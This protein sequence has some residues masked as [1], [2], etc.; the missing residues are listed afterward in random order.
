[1]PPGQRIPRRRGAWGVEAFPRRAEVDLTSQTALKLP[2]SERGADGLVVRDCRRRSR[3]EV[4]K[5]AGRL[6]E[7]NIGEAMAAGEW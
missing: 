5:S 6:T 1:M 7:G 2:L 3:E 4:C